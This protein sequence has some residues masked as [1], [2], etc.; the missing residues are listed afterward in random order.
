MWK[1]ATAA[2]SLWEGN[3]PGGLCFYYLTSVFSLTQAQNGSRIIIPSVPPLP[4]PLRGLCDKPLAGS[5]PLVLPPGWQKAILHFKFALI[6]F[7]LQKRYVC[8]L[9]KKSENMSQNEMNGNTS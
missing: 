7:L 3:V 1:G 5:A 4:S 2:L 6:F 9:F 8:S